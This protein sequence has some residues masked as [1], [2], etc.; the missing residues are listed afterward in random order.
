[1]AMP[2]LPPDSDALPALRRMR[3]G[4]PFAILVLVV[5]VLFVLV[6]WDHARQREGSRYQPLRDPKT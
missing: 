3:Y 4:Y 5:S 1:M 2:H 6:A